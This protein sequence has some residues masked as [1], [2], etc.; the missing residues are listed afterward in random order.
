MTQKN[1]GRLL[2]LFVF[3][4]SLLSFQLWRNEAQAQSSYYT[5]MGCVNCHTTTATCNG[6][7]AHGT[8]ATSTKNTI[9]VSGTTNKTSYAP[10]ETVSVTIAGGYRTGWVRAVLLDQSGTQ[11]A[12][13]TGT[14]S[15]MGSSTTL[16]AILTAPAPT[17]AGTYTWQVGWYGNQYDISSAAFGSWTPDANNP[18][19]GYEMVSTN[20]FTVAAAPAADTTAPVVGSFTLP[21]TAT[22]LAVPV[23]AFTATDNVAVT[24]YLVTTSSAVPSASA[25]GWSATAPASVTAVEGSNTFYAWA[26]DA[27]G[28]VSAA[29][30]ATVTV[31]LPDTTAPVVGSFT[32]PATATTLTV[33]VSAFTATDNVAVTGYLV[34]TSSAAPSASAAGW[35]ATAPASVTA[36]AGSNTFYA[37]AKDAAGNVSA[38]RSATVTVTLPDTTAPVVGTFTLP[39]TATSLTVPVSAFTA[40]DNVA[41]TGYL[42]TTSSAAPSASAAGWSATA[43]ASVT[44]VAGSNTFYAWAKDA[45][46]NVSAAKSAT[47]TVTLPDTT[48][49]VVGSFALPATATTLTVPVS[50]FTASDNV[51][52]TGY[53]ISTGS[54]APSASAIGW[55]MAPPAVV[56]AV[57]GNNTFYAFAKDAAGNVSAGKSATVTVTIPAPTADTT[58]PTLV[59]STLADG[60]YTNKVTLNISGSATD[61]GGL[62]SLTIN[63]QAVAVNPDG[64]FSAAVTLV[65]GANVITVVAADQAGNA[66]SDVRTITFDPTAPV[67]S[68]TAPGDNSDSAQSFTTVT[69]TV[70]ESS[71]VTVTDNGGNQTSA[72]ISGNTFSAT[73]NLVAGV[74]TITITATDLAGN[75]TSAKRTVTYTPTGALTMAVTYPA[76]DITTSKSSIVL[77]GTVADTVGKAT[78]LVKMSGRTY[79]PRVDSTGLFKQ[80]LRFLKNGTYVI[81]VTATDAAGNSSTVTRNVIYRKATLSELRL[82]RKERY[83]D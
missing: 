36:V 43:P 64:S 2:V 32:L 13:S 15:G 1:Q 3:A 76:Q 20:S 27:A 54:A 49:P 22:T 52:V 75:V 74:N 55:S 66:Q 30:S 68:I 31:T 25:A 21:A 69:G 48:A 18:N 12:I 17:A 70:D 82:K 34:T 26:K 4:L 16:P 51:A 19:H 9:N 67:L 33:P 80:Q 40:T 24:G 50:A 10:G 41:V 37:W 59:V 11:L 63:G 83:D 77:T 78:V 73:V 45:A 14:A 39:A 5:T 23:S 56:T 29:K 35:S 57:E 44:A 46:G 7:H 53:L 81:T 28:N 6:C 42:V 72:A 38:A 58:N 8:H 79:K 71:T 62:Q 60:S 47:V 61:A 65:A